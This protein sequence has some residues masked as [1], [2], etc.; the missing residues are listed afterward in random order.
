MTD[1]DKVFCRPHWFGLP[2]PLRD[3]IWDAYRRRDRSASLHNIMEA[4]RWY[5]A[6]LEEAR[7]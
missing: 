3:A 6:K 2:K 4:V 7:P 1:D 5:R